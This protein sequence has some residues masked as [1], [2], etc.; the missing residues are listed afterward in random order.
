MAKLRRLALIV[1][2]LAAAL[3]AGG[4]ATAQDALP[5][6]AD[7]AKVQSLIST[8]QDEGARAQLIEQLRLL[9]QAQEADEP[10]LITDGLG[11]HLLSIVSDR[12]AQVSQSLAE[13][14]TAI[15]AAPAALH[16]VVR[17]ASDPVARGRWIEVAFKVLIVLG[18]ATA[19]EI[20]VIR[21]L[22]RFRRRLAEQP[23]NGWWVKI[24]SVL[25]RAILE[26]LP[27]LAFA[28]AAYG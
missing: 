10:Q 28:A 23:R 20:A 13:A 11:A 17:E 9:T 16:W 7:A 4:P 25:A 27:I 19:I 14:G 12:V 24:L 5:P 18:L 15:Y 8:L 6:A 3:L 22:S 26:L 21:F 2:A 1:L